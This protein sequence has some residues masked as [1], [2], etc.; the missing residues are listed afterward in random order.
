MEP[1]CPET[2]LDLLGSHSFSWASPTLEHWHT[3]LWGSNYTSSCLLWTSLSW[4]ETTSLRPSVRAQAGSQDWAQDLGVVEGMDDWENLVLQCMTAWCQHFPRIQQN[5][6]SQHLSWKTDNWSLF[7]EICLVLTFYFLL[8]CPGT[9]CPGRGSHRSN[10]KNMW[11]V[12]S[13]HLSDNSG[14]DSG[15][16]FRRY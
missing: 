8:K 13:I 3:I 1:L 5:L 10:L 2:F 16:Q 9:F 7:L 11:W 6:F 14:S 15:T 4:E 12:C